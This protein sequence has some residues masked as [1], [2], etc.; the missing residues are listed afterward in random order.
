MCSGRGECKNLEDGYECDCEPNYSGPNCEGKYWN[1]WLKLFTESP[2]RGGG[3]G[4][5]AELYLFIYFK[6]W[7]FFL[8]PLTTSAQR[9]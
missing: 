3:G 6:C 9:S 1:G 4:G 7:C 5:G 8:A 2:G